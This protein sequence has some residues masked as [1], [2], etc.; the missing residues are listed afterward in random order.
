MIKLANYP[1]LSALAAGIT[2]AKRLDERACRYLY[3]S[4][5]DKIDLRTISPAEQDLMQRLG[6]SLGIAH[7]DR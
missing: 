2:Q 4:N 6:I 5:L 7:D 3:E 1:V